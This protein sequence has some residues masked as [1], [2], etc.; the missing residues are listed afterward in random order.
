MQDE[1]DGARRKTILVVDDNPEERAIFSTYLGFVGY[2]VETASN[3]EECLERARSDRHSLILLDLGMP[4]LD[5]WKTMERLA[6]SRDTSQIP[7]MALTAYHLEPQVLEDAG[8]C[9]YLEKPIAPYRVLT[10]VEQCIGRP[11]PGSPPR[12]A[13]LR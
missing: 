6:A 12:I 10:E 13:R 5:G 2:D 4:V 9:G 11:A 3:G 7:V 8:F 1:L